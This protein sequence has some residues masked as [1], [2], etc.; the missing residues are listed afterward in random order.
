MMA[1]VLELPPDLM[2][3]VLTYYDQFPRAIGTTIEKFADL[4]RRGDTDQA[5]QCARKAQALAQTINDPVDES[6]FW[7]WSADLYREVAQLG[8]ALKCCREAN[9]ALRL[10]PT[11]EHRDH[12]EAVVAYVQGL[13]RHALGD[14]AEA[15]ANYQRSLEAFDGA[16]AHWGDHAKANPSQAGK[17]NGL[18]EE[19]RKAVKW[20]EVLS[21]HLA[22]EF[23]LIGSGME[24]YITVI[25]G[26]GYDLIRLVLG[27]H[28]LP[29]EIQIGDQPYRLSDPGSGAPLKVGP[30]APWNARYFA[31][32]VLADQWA[33]PCSTRKDYIL[34]QREQQLT[35]PGA[36]AGVLWDTDQERWQYG[37]FTRDPS[38][39]E[40]RFQPLPPRVIGADEEIKHPVGTIQALLKP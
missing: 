11:Y 9:N 30:T 39:G 3:R 32:R 26:Q 40:I 7:V 13:I 24:M 19:C 37:R 18:A 28:R 31:M 4:W 27:A 22:S 25:D 17:Y 38:T 29:L 15:L 10:R 2:P 20:I 21:Q 12:A 1:T 34:V 6:V 5:I 8:P 23:S 36:D 35:W 16:T 14:K 33:G